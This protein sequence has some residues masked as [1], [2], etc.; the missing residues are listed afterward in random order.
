MKSAVYNWDSIAKY[1]SF[2]KLHKKKTAFLLGLWFIGSVSYF[3]LILGAAYAPG[4][5]K[6]KII[7]R[8][9]LGYL[10]CISQFFIMIA[11]AIYY[12]HRAN[13][14]FDPLTRQVLDEIHSGGQK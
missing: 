3:M 1:P 11:I 6:V 12:T 9:N 14:Y 7:G 2:I 10:V 4:L 13:T 8:M 5:F